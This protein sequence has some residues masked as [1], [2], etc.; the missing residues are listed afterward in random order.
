MKDRWMSD[1]DYIML[2]F[3]TFVIAFSIIIVIKINHPELDNKK[4]EEIVITDSTPKLFKIKINEVSIY[5]SEA[6]ELYNDNDEDINLTGYS[7]NDKSGKIYKFPSKVISKKGYL[8]ITN[9]ELG[10]DINNSNEIIYLK[11]NGVTIDYFNV[12]KLVENISTGV[13]NGNKVYYQNITLGTKNSDTIFLGFSEAPEFSINGGYAKVGDIVSLSTKDNSTIYYTIDGSFPTNQSTKY[14]GPITISKNMVIKAIS[15]REGYLASDVIS[16]TFITERT[17]DLPIVSISVDN[18]NFYNNYQK[19][20]EQK[21]NFEFYEKDGSYGVSFTGDIKVSGWGSARPNQK[22]MSVYLRKKYGTT[23]IVYPFYDNNYNTYSSFLLRAGG[24]TKLH[25]TEG[26]LNSIIKDD[27][28]LDIRTYRPVVVYINGEYWGLYS[29]LEKQNIDFLEN[30]YGIDKKKVDIIKY[31]VDVFATSNQ[32]KK[33]VAYGNDKAFNN[34]LNYLYTHNVQDNN[35]YSYLKTQIDMQN[36][37]NFWI[38]ES[39]CGNS[40]Y[41]HNNVRIYKSSDGKWRW[42]LYDLDYCAILNNHHDN[43]LYLQI[44]NSTDWVTIMKKLAENQEFRALYLTSLGKYL[45]TT[46]KPDRA[47]AIID[48]LVSEVEKE[49]PYE[50]ERWHY[51]PASMAEWRNYIDKTKTSFQ[52]RYSEVVRSLKS[53]FNLSDSEYNKYFGELK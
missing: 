23:K 20:E 46:F 6:I 14:T 18:M 4:E 45:K 16:R 12:N 31:Y 17:H 50:I 39:Y 53:R 24:N 48:K 33:T 47:I 36:L 7:L 30:K 25:I 11:Y 40:D 21:T 5:P 29:L 13:S 8:V 37:I 15:Y 42:M 22:S 43:F 28:D 1:E 19:K 49:M 32:V 26:I 2:L 44:N 3:L 38:V 52:S 34:L 41:P 51:M 35:V 9:N 27:M 10:F